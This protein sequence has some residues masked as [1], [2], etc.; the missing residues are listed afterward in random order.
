MGRFSS[1]RGHP[2]HAQK[3]L[4][5]RREGIRSSRSRIPIAS[6]GEYVIGINFDEALPYLDEH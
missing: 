2:V 5:P 1:S 3:K 4:L 6:A